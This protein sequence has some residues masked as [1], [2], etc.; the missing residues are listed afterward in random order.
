MDETWDKHYQA[1]PELTAEDNLWN[2]IESLP[3]LSLFAGWLKEYGYD[4]LLSQ[5]QAYTVF[6]PNN[7]A[8]AG[9]D[10]TGKNIKTEWI[11][12][13]VA[14]FIIPASGNTAFAVG[15]LNK[16][17]IDI[18]NRDGN[19]FFGSTPFSVSS[20]SKVASNGI[21]HV[22]NGYEVFSPNTWEYL[23]KRTDLDSIKNCF[24]AF[25]EIVFDESSSVPG[26]VVD[27]QLTYLD[28]VFFNRNTLLSR[29]GY[30]NREDSS[31]L[32]LVPNNTAWTEAYDRIKEDFVYYNPKAAVADSLQRTHTGF[33]LVQD[34][35]FNHTTQASPQDSLTSTSRN[36]FYNP[37]YLFEGSEP[38]TTSN[39]TVYITD[40]LRFKPWESWRKPI[41]VEAERTLGRENTLSTPRAERATGAAGT[42][43]GGRY[44]NLIPSTSSGNPTVA[45]EIPNTLSTYYDIYCVF[46]S[47]L[48]NTPNADKL[49]ACKVYFNL[50]YFNTDGNQVID[51]FPASGTIETNPYVMDT[52]LVASNFKFPTPITTKKLQR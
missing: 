45:F 52:V 12:N 29:L 36:T 30:I 32:M 46:V 6:A 22:L 4:Q 17:R 2:T 50:S 20:K 18:T 25:D 41:T 23:A 38:V 48:V 34:L 47:G 39:G 35:I 31:Y 21:V 11:D 7:E 49:L 43:S 26:S 44:L 42:V 51:R 27:G 9:V 10:T 16:K 37:Y 14:R 40:R 3:E 24:Y 15:T 13:H 8:L 28:S 5:S 33:A 1:N 19:Y